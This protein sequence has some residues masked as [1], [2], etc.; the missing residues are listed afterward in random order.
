MSPLFAFFNDSFK[1]KPL[2][3]TVTYLNVTLKIQLHT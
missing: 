2:K 3:V 1:M